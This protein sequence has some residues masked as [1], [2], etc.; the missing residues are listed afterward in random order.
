MAGFRRCLCSSRKRE[1]PEELETKDGDRGHWDHHGEFL[2][3]LLGFAVGLGNIWRFPYLCMRN[4]GG[5]FLIPY[6]IAIIIIGFPAMFLELV[7]GQFSGL[8]PSRVWSVVPIFQGI[9]WGMAI[10]M[11]I[12]SCSYGHLVTWILYYLG[13]SFSAQLPWTNCNNSWNT[14]NCFIY[15]ANAS[16]YNI[17]DEMS[18]YSNVSDEWSNSSMILNATL[19]TR[20]SPGEEFFRYNVLELT[21]GAED[22]GGLRWQLVLCHLAGWAIA[23]LGV[24]KGIKSSGKA[25]YVT[26]LVPYI[27]LTIL[28]IRGCLLPGA[29]DGIIYYIKPDFSKLLEFRIWC[30]AAIQIFYSV[31][32]FGGGNITYA[33]Y[34]KF[35]N[36]C[37]RDTFFVVTLN[38]LTSLYGGFAVFAVVGYMAH[39][40]GLPVDKVIQSGPGLA[41]IVYPEALSKLPLPQLWSV[42]FFL[43]LATLAIGTQFGHLQTVVACLTDAFPDQLKGK[44]HWI[45][46]T[47]CCAGCA[48]ALVFCTRGGMYWFQLVD[49]Y[50][51]TFS[52]FVTLTCGCL[53]LAW[54]YGLNRLFED[55]EMMIGKKPLF[56]FKIFWGGLTPLY[57]LVIFIYNCIGF[58]KPSYGNYQYPNWAITIAWL[59]PLVSMIQLPIHAIIGIAK[60]K[61]SLLKRLRILSHPGEDWAPQAPEYREEYRNKHGPKKAALPL[62][63]DILTAVDMSNGNAAGGSAFAEETERDVFVFLPSAPLDV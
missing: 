25:V 4:G 17:S 3:T 49:W 30:E 9:G 10:M 8:S 26:S 5:S 16:W 29:V 45:L 46:L 32:V 54:L 63:L 33:S 24:I 1:K 28:L 41:F 38:C 31:G 55:I 48:I 56:I 13:M 58:S 19:D 7:I 57:V 2:L 27:L 59:V 15:K 12:A 53:G 36:N 11:V 23:S 62:T 35:H 60:E 40:T 37:L 42:L 14:E 20:V 44:G 34:N 52:T 61:G 22:L 21:D 50:G 43:M 6:C 47:H 18:W 51:V 39:E